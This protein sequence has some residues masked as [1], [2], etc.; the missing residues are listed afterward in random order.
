MN[1][2]SESFLS[3]VLSFPQKC[4]AYTQRIIFHSFIGPV[5]NTLEV[6]DR[7]TGR[8][9]KF[10]ISN[11]AVEAVHFRAIS[12]GSISSSNDTIQDGLKILDPGFQNT[13]VMRSNVTFVCVSLR[14]V[15]KRSAS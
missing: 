11:N 14:S 6:I 10:P 13:A 1:S 7:R 4:V 8:R 12:T 5:S 9:F 15:S 2:L 3:C